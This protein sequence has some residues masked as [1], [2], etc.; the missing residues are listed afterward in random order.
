[1]VK[2]IMKSKTKT[3]TPGTYTGGGLVDG[4]R[5]ALVACPLCGNVSSLSDHTIDNEGVVTPSLICPYPGCSFH[6]HVILQ[7]W[8]DHE[9]A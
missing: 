5:T 9:T 4:S 2:V 6:E 7:D 3:L 1:M 8:I